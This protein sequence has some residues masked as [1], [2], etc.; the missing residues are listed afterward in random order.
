MPKIRAKKEKEKEKEEEE[1]KEEK[2][3]A[4]SALFLPAEKSTQ[5]KLNW[6]NA[7]S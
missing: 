6:F 7:F 1:E 5:G 3:E 2:G 4:L